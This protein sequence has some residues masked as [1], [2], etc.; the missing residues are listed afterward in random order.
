MIIRMLKDVTFKDRAGAV[1]AFFPAGSV[2]NASGKTQTTFLTVWGGIYFD[3]A[4]E[5]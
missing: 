1:V 3:E 2:I 4:E 5:V